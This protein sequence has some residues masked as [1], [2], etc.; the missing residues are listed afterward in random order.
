MS[1]VFLIPEKPEPLETTDVDEFDKVQSLEGQKV[2][3]GI[4]SV[5]SRSAKEQ[6]THVVTLAAQSLE[7]EALE[8]IQEA[9]SL[10]EMNRKEVA[11]RHAE[12]SGVRPI[13]MSTY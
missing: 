10:K 13:R 3:S 12:Q 4:K 9:K 7:M 6:G 1:Q 11:L 5:A 8:D 2:K